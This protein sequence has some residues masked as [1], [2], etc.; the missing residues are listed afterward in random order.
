[1]CEAI[2]RL[3]IGAEVMPRGVHFRVWAPRAE[4][5]A[6]VFE[7]RALET[8]ELDRE[9]SGYFSGLAPQARP[10]SRYR[11][12][13][14]GR[15]ELWPDPASRYQPTGSRGASQ[16][17]DLSRYNWQDAPW[18]GV[19]LDAVVLYEMHVGT[20]TQAG[21]WLA[22]TA[23]LAELA[24]LGVTVLELMPI[25]EF[26]GTFGWSYDGSNL[27]A[28]THLYGTPE[29]LWRV[30]RRSAPTSAWE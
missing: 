19:S 22:A 2:R 26:P 10:G 16:I 4:R 15:G 7:P 9:A 5:V 21:T 20:F 14:D 24:A 18:T 11:F 23:E 1:M 30:C 3:P 25:T 6:V 12:Q 28:P 8:I 17:V 27:F 29:E 13:L